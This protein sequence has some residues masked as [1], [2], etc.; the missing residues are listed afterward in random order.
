MIKSTTIHTADGSTV[1]ITP[2]GI[3]YDLHVQSAAGRS[4]ATVVMNA[5][6]LAALIAEAEEV[7]GW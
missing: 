5:D 4:I 1:S 2:R 7:Q 3:E 6:D